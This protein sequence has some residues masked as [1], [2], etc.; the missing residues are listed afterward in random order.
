MKNNKKNDTAVIDTYYEI[1]LS[2][3]GGQGLILAGIILAEAAVLDGF[4]VAQTQS[5]GPEAR[6]GASRSDVVISNQKIFYPKTKNLDLLL[7]LNQA[8]C[9][10]YFFDL[11]SKGILILDTT[12]I[13][14]VPT[15]L[16][17]AYPISEYARDKFNN[18]IVANIISLG[19]IQGLT[20]IVQKKSM[21]M[22]ITNRV[23]AQTHDLNTRAVKFGMELGMKD[24]ARAMDMLNNLNE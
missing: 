11:K 8:S 2:G 22:A 7:A 5:Y 19:I 3:S 21:L 12:N 9:D 16:A 24:A 23:P 15:S 18:P 6:G 17:F 14:N 1:R 4:N 13:S 10:K 20:G